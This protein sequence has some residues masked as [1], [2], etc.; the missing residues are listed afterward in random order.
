MR[1]VKITL[2]ALIILLLSFTK[3]YA[4]S[5]EAT[6]TPDKT[7]VKA[8]DTVTVTMLVKCATGIEALDSTLKYDKKQLEL[9]NTTVDKSFKDLSGENASTGEYKLSFLF[10]GNEAPKQV[11]MVKLSFKVLDDVKAN[12]TINVALSN[13]QVNDSDDKW[14][15]IENQSTTLK[16]VAKSTEENPNENTAGGD[17]T[18]G[19]N[20]AEDNTTGNNT[21]EDNTTGNNTKSDKPLSYAGLENYTFAIIAITVLVAVVAYAK[22]KQ[23]KNI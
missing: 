12:D 1:K 19:N 3:V 23:Y 16:V 13:I 6:L 15:E 20:T 11:E 2:L 5:A 21:V 4:E 22:Y 10:D 14:M 9:T 8:G 17:N 7:E 18:T